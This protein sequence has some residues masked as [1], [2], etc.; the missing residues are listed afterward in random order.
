M[1][2]NDDIDILLT[3]NPN[4][5]SSCF[6]FVRNK[7]FD[8]AITHVFSDPYLD[9]IQALA[10]LI[11]GEKDTTFYWYCEQGGYK[12]EI[13]KLMTQQDTVIVSINEFSELFYSEPKE[14]ELIVTFEI[15]LKQLITIFYLQLQ[16]TYFLLRDKQF[17]EN[18]AKNF[19][20]QE[21]HKFEKLVKPFL[22]L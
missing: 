19:P 3:L 13:K 12:F 14:Y 1:E 18:R 21:F 17:S 16:K 2:Q 11:R 20:F 5:W 4:G 22:G 10:N 15:K 7:V 9:L 8:F 6:L